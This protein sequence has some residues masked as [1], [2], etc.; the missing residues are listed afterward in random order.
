[1]QMEFIGLNWQCRQIFFGGILNQV[2]HKFKKQEVQQQK[3][4][5]V[6]FSSETL[7]SIQHKQ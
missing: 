4:Q 2:T 7:Q 3:I 6:V 1:M 5:K